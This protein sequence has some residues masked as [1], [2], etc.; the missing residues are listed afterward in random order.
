MI[1]IRITLMLAWTYARL[2][3]LRAQPNRGEGIVT[4]VAMIVGFLAIVLAALAILKPKVL[5][6]FSDLAFK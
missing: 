2:Q 3:R 5:G 6:A 4:T 1:S